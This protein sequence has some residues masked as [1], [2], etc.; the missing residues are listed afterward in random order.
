MEHSLELKKQFASLVA[1]GSHP[2]Q[3]AIRIFGDPNEAVKYYS[4][5]DRDP[6]V[7]REV[8]RLKEECGDSL[9]ISKEDFAEEV[10][11]AAQNSKDP[12]AKSSLYSLY[13]EIRGFVGKNVAVEVNNVTNK[14]MVVQSHGSNEDWEKKLKTSQLKLIQSNARAV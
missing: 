2:F 5:L 7:L 12:K 8:T 11:D 13:A 6:V 3:A 14:V 10:R 9:L 4:G 1:G